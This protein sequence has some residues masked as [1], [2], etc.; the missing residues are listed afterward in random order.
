VYSNELTTKLALCR[1]ITT[2]GHSDFS[3][4][5]ILTGLALWFDN[6]DGPFI[7]LEWFR[8]AIL[9]A[10]AFYSEAL[11]AQPGDIEIRQV[12]AQMWNETLLGEALKTYYKYFEK[13]PR[14]AAVCTAIAPRQAIFT[15]THE[16]EPGFAEETLRRRGQLD[17]KPW[18]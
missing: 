15:S 17:S 3:I 18:E 13:D 2:V 14:L 7:D 11:M 6:P 12:E 16:W 9:D 5:E 1:S 4:E 10:K 8:L